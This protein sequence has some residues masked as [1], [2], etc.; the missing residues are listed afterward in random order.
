MA[1]SKRGSQVLS[2][3][4]A[5][6]P[7]T[8]TAREVDG[9]P[10]DNTTASLDGVLEEGCSEEEELGEE[11]L[12]FS[13]SEED[14]PPPSSPA[15]VASDIPASSTP[16]VPVPPARPKGAT[17][18]PSSSVQVDNPAVP[19][20]VNAELRSSINVTLPNGNPLIQRVIYET[21]PKFGK[22][23]KVLGHSTG[24][25]SKGKAEA[26]TVKKADPANVASEENVKDKGSVFTRLNPV[27]DSLVDDSPAA[28]PPVESSPDATPPVDA[29][30]LDAPSV[31][32]ES[33]VAQD[34][35]PRPQVTTASSKEWQTVCKR[36]HSSRNKRQTPTPSPA[37]CNPTPQHNVYSPEAQF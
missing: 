31:P 23:C 5:P 20:P 13:C 32:S 1:K 18:T 12:D 21:L 24:A 10:V 19:P 35:Q 4:S 30:E 28:A 9:S 2:L 22:H 34:V 15:P 11:Q 17:F 29:P 25:C 14:Y 16:V 7:G 6:G 33:C 27:V 3:K 36:R 37:D 8:S 26:R